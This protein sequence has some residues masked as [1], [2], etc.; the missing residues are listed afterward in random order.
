MA[1]GPKLRFEIFKR[2]KFTCQYCGRKPPEVVLNVDHV[3]AQA[4]GGGDDATNLITSCFTCNSGKSDR[5]VESIDAPQIYSAEDR[6]RMLEMRR[7]RL[8]QVKAI[9]AIGIEEQKVRDEEALIR[10]DW[11]EQVLMRWSVKEGWTKLGDDVYHANDRFKAA[12]KKIVKRMMVADIFEA[13]DIAFD[14]LPPPASEWNRE[15]YFFG[16]CWRKIKGQSPSF[17]K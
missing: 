12:V 4:S 14:K 13:M 8:A 7:E 9:E 16:V 2:D 6:E 10:D 15:K 1:I 17:K 11:E 3:L 5:P